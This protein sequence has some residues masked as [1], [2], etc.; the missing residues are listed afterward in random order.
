MNIDFKGVIYKGTNIL[1]NKI[2]IGQT[3]NFSRRMGSHKK[4][5]FNPNSNAY[6]THLSSSIRKYGWGNF[7]WEIICTVSAKT[8][9]TLK[10]GLNWLEM[11]YIQEFDSYNNGMNCTLGGG[12]QL[13]WIPSEETRK[14]ISQANIGRTS[15]PRQP[16]PEE[17]RK[18]YSERMKGKYIGENNPNYGRRHTDIAKQKMREA[19]LGKPGPNKGKSPSLETREKL[20][21]AKLGT[22]HTEEAR[23]KMSIARIGSNSIRSRAVVQLD[24]DNNFIREW[25]CIADAVRCLEFRS[26]HISDVCN[27]IR[28][29]SNGYKWLYKEDYYD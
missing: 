15:Y 3:V 6:N 25:D 14:K 13:G 22:K 20:R 28:N 23:K 17:R 12:S 4:S 9:E 2:Y 26:N 11:Y 18:Q 16:M 5:A 8:K 1:N 21:Q 29:T 24:Y 10:D 27:G 7:D 19:R